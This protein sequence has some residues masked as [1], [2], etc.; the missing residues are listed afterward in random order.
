MKFE[1]PFGSVHA[2][3]RRAPEGLLHDKTIN[4]LAAPLLSVMRPV[5][6]RAGC[7]SR[8]LPFVH[9]I[10]RVRVEDR[11]IARMAYHLQRA[12]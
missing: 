10:R 5:V 11:L 7:L 12:D 3:A 4:P 6:Q 8:N 9:L 2:D 1:V